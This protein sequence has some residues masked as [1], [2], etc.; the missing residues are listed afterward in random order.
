[1]EKIALTLYSL[2]NH[3]T[4][5]NDFNKTLERVRNMGY[6]YVQVSGVP[7]KPE[8]IRKVFDKHGLICCATH[9]SLG[10]LEDTDALCDRLAVLGCDFAAIGYPGGEY[11]STDG[12]SRLA[13]I[14]NTKG[15]ELLKKGIKLGYHNHHFEL[16]R[17]ADGGTLL[18]KFYRDTDA[19]C[20]FAEIDTYWIARGGGSPFAWIN[21]VAGRM[22][23]VHFKDFALTENMEPVSAV[24]KTG[25]VTM[26]IY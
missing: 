2:R 10:D 26:W 15:R 24:L 13:A 20:V 5:E 11:F 23:V 19:K 1:M 7:F 8:V 22:P 21:R 9:Q 25:A 14:M 17:A 3:C 12:I 6:R 4:N 16:K 18:E